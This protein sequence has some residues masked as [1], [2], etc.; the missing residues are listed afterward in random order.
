MMILMNVQLLG[1]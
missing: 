1:L